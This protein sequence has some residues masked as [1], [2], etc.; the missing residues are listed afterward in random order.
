MSDKADKTG[1]QRNLI[2]REPV[3][4]PEHVSMDETR[5]KIAR[6]MGFTREYA[7]AYYERGLKAYQDGDLENA[8]LDLSE[9][10][11]YDRKF[12][13]YYSTRGLF[14][15]ENNQEEEAELDLQYALTLS[16]RQWLAHYALGILDFKH[17]DYE[18][19]LKH[20]EEAAQLSPTRPEVWYYRAVAQ[21]YV[22]DDEKALAD[23][24][25]A[26]D[27]F[28]DGDKRLKDV[29]A[30]MKELKKNAPATPK[31]PSTPPPLK[32]GSEPAQLEAPDDS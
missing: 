9:A 31:S 19:A 29:T 22:G 10:I 7:Q 14:Y 28:P 30:W 2:K 15:L 32:R 5:E 8:I 24:E 13:E 27:L 18:P 12:P 6:R 11:F 4:P 21:H 1:P 16:K 20:F 26:E 25:Q 17:G 23:L 3:P